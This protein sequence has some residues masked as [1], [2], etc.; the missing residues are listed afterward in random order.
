MRYGIAPL[1][2]RPGYSSQVRNSKPLVSNV[3]QYRNQCIRG[4]VYMVECDTGYSEVC[5]LLDYAELLS[6]AIDNPTVWLCVC[7]QKPNPQ[8]HNTTTSGWGFYVGFLPNKLK[9][10]VPTVNEPSKQLPVPEIDNPDM[11][12]LTLYNNAIY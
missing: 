7:A 5:S 11:P 2:C 4:E 3:K 12:D 8:N 6:T 9:R 1:C 10:P